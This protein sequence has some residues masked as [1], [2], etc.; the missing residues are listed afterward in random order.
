MR[1]FRRAIPKKLKKVGWEISS[2]V[3]RLEIYD[4]KG[5]RIV[6]STRFGIIIGVYNIM[7]FSK[8][9]DVRTIYKKPFVD[10][11]SQFM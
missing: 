4:R 1:R 2:I 6:Y 11:I 7:D 3:N 8:P 5:E 10:K 9:V